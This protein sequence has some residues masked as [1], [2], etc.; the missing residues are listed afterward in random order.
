MKHFYEKLVTI[1][2]SLI[3]GFSLRLWK[4]ESWDSPLLKKVSPTKFWWVPVSPIQHDESWLFMHS[5]FTHSPVLQ[6]LINILYCSCSLFMNK[7]HELEGG[8]LYWNI[9]CKVKYLLNKIQKMKIN[10]F[11]VYVHSMIQIG[12]SC[13][14]I[15]GI[16]VSRTH[17][18]SYWLY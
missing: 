5:P 17:L 9:T 16:N 3:T 4:G 13:R 10:A 18:V 14:C 1:S 2:F 8:R 12:R 11:L 6:P 15:R 7:M